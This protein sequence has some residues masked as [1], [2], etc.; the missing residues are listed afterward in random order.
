[1]SDNGWSREEEAQ[2][3]AAGVG[4]G[5]ESCSEPAAGVPGRAGGGRRGAWQGIGEWRKKSQSR[6]S[7]SDA[8]E[9]KD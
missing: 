2:G 3:E 6:D 9:Q 7:T 8:T 5:A 1:M 4:V